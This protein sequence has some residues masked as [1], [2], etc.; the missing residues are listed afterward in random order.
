MKTIQGC[1]QN[2]QQG[3]GPRTFT[4]YLVILISRFF[5]G[6]IFLPFLS[7]LA[8][9]FDVMVLSPFF[10]LL[11]MAGRTDGAEESVNWGYLTPH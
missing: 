10:E 5:V 4:I 11:P 7:F 1:R 2:R 9:F 8:A 3:G 6:R